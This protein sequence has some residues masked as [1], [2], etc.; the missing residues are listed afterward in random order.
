MMRF[1]IT[2]LA[3][4][5]A[6]LSVS[7]QAKCVL[8]VYG[9]EQVQIDEFAESGRTARELGT[10]AA[11]DE[12][13]ARVVQRIALNRQE[14]S[15][16]LAEERAEDY[17][18][19]VHIRS[20]N[21]LPKRYMAELDICFDAARVRTLFQAGGLDF[22]ELPS[23]P[24]VVLPVFAQPSGV[25]LWDRANSWIAGWAEQTSRHDGLLSFVSLPEGL[26]T[27]RQLSENLVYA[28]DQQVLAVAARLAGA[29]QL[30]WA[31]AEIDYSQT[32]PRLLIR[33]RLFDERGQLV[34]PLA[35]EEVV[36]TGQQN[37]SALFSRFQQ[38]IT[39][40][41]EQRWRRNNLVLQGA[42]ARLVVSAD[43]RG[44]AQW[45]RLQA[46]LAG[47]PE[48]LRVVPLKL[49]AT[50][51]TVELQL[52]GSL[53]ALRTALQLQGWELRSRSNGYR[54]VRM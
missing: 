37:M 17:L 42:A 34:A 31:L 4:C 43:L 22:A 2:F 39:D 46:D 24:V 33:A 27:E 21:A 38:R 18:D 53:S 52:A 29:R 7:A 9:A 28:E 40:D 54:L 36:L 3:I 16:L 1:H 12:A 15:Q 47:L 44:L 32:R 20:E 23:A 5:L 10:T 45:H 11:V 26:L 6:L 19:F 50:Q 41:L 14:A 13:F 25:R 8:P 48:I 49:S 30:V 35:A 51:G